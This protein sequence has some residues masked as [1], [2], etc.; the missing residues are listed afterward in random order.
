MVVLGVLVLLVPVVDPFLAHRAVYLAG[1]VEFAA[2]ERNQGSASEH[3]IGLH[4]PVF[5]ERLEG[6]VEA[7][8][9]VGAVDAVELLAYVIVGR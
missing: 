1:V 3:L 9:Q 7:R 6:D 2:V 4:G 8:L 5:A